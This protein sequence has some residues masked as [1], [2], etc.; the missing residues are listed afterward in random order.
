MNIRLDETIS[1]TKARIATTLSAAW[2]DDYIL[3]GGALGAYTLILSGY[4]VGISVTFAILEDNLVI[5]EAHLILRDIYRSL[6]KLPFY[7]QA[8]AEYA[9]L[10][11]AKHHWGLGMERFLL[12][13]WFG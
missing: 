1:E 10:R 7:I 12:D 4:T 6:D 13:I 2:K 5:G 3:S 9:R 8:L 11:Q